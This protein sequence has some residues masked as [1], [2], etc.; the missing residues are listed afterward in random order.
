MYVFSLP[1]IPL[2][3]SVNHQSHFVL[4]VVACGS[5]RCCGITAMSDDQHMRNLL[6][7]CGE[8]II[9]MLF[10]DGH[11]EFLSLPRFLGWIGILLVITFLSRF[12]IKSMAGCD[13]ER[14]PLRWVYSFESHCMKISSVCVLCQDSK[15]NTLKHQDTV[16]CYH[17]IRYLSLSHK[18]A[19]NTG[20]L[21]ILLSLKKPVS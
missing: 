8:G 2:M 12:E 17:N 14:R 15:K 1:P 19:T 4:L 13:Y 5:Y 20:H 18:Y 16:F 9:V 21:F 7:L 6:M 3:G 11:L 10:A